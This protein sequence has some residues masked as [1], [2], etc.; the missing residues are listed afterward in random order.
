[1]T[2]RHLVSTHILFGPLRFIW[3]FITFFTLT[4]VLVVVKPPTPVG[5]ATWW[6]ARS[7]NFDYVYLPNDPNPPRRDRIWNY[8]V[9]DAV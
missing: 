8:D 9:N 2:D 5:A 6:T 7:G 1:M 3:L 4:S